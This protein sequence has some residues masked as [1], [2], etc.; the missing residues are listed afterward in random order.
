[1][2]PRCSL[3]CGHFS[4]TLSTRNWLGRFRMTDQ[5]RCGA[6][7]PAAPGR[8]FLSLSPSVSLL[9][10]RPGTYRGPM[11]LLQLARPTRG[12]DLAG[13][14]CAAL[15]N[16]LIR[17][18]WSGEAALMAANCMSR[19][20]YANVAE[21]YYRRAGR[22]ELNDLQIRAFAL[23]LGPQSRTG[24]SRLQRD[25][26]TLTRK[27]D[28]HAA[29]RRRLAGCSPRTRARSTPQ[30]GRASRPGCR[31]RGDRFDTASRCRLS[32]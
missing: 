21:R 27:C 13:G 17:Q 3:V 11:Q 26:G 2:L 15:S 31:R 28:G 18:P 12:S 30:A 16:T 23:A 32:Q 6:V 7:P 24:D 14:S 8:L 5:I 19:L 20:S 22:L 1:M 9:A 4:C 25:P 10:S 29:A